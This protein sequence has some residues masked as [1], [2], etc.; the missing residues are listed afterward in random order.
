MRSTK[1][2]AAIFTD[3][4]IA[5]Y[6]G[7]KKTATIQPSLNGWESLTGGRNG[8]DGFVSQWLL[9]ITSYHES[10]LEQLTADN[11]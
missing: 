4:S 11:Y 3:W 5:N 10:I 6:E 1:H 7:V 8:A 9:N 2:K